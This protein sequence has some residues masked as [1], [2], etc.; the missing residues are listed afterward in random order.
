MKFSIIFLVTLLTLV[1]AQ[2]GNQWSK[3]DREIFDL[4]LAVQKDLN[5][6][7]SKP[8][9]FYQW[10]DTER[11][12][13][14]DDVTKSYRKLSRQLHP[15]KNRKVAGATDRFTRLGLVYKILINKDLRK[16]YDFYLKN[17]FPR[18]GE[19]GEFVFKRF[20]PGVGFALFV[21]YFLIGLGSYVVKY[22]NA[23]KIKSTIERVEREVRKEA[24]RKNGVRLPATTDVIV[25]GRQYCYYNTG[26]IHLVD[27][28]TNVEHP[29]SSQEVVM[30]GVKDS[31]WVTFP[32]ALFNLVR[33][34][35]AAEKAEAAKIEQEKAAKAER[36]RPKPKAA[37]KVGGRRRK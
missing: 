5:P 6:D 35:S 16:R 12:A 28:D 19:N 18:E 1:F 27:T 17:G 10:L 22:L 13:S 31:L 37:T 11:K 7:N 14:V 30:P 26:E 24:S 29:I 33:P 8:V 4:H 3:E 15:D 2:G 32:V 20:K 23:R 9:S 34:K 36:E 25:D 21:L